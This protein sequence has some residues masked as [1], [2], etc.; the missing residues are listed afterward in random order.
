MTDT[1]I[2]VL[3][4]GYVGLTTAALLAASGFTTYIIDPNKQRLDSIRN[5]KS[6]FYEAGLDPLVAAG[7]E[8][9][10]LIPTDSYTEAIPESTIVFSAVGTP[11][12]S[13][14]SSN[15]EY[16]FAAAR[17]AARHMQPGS[18]YVQKS[19]VPVGTGAQVEK[20][21]ADSGKTFS[22]VSNPEFLRESTA[23]ADSL[24]PER[25]VVGGRD[26]SALNAV[27][28]IYKQQQH[29]RSNIAALAGITPPSDHSTEQYFMTSL[30]SAE[31]IK[32]SANAYLSL[33][34]SFANSIAKLADKTGAD[35]VEVMTA[36][37]ADRRIGQAFLN[38]GRGYGGGCF[39]KDVAGLISA[40][41]SF[42]VEP[43]IME[44]AQAVNESM[45]AYVIEKLQARLKK[46]IKQHAVAV[47]GLSFKAGTSD[48]R[49]SPGITIANLLA[50]S[51][52]QVR[53][54]DPQAM[55]EAE[56][57]LAEQIH[58]AATTVDALNGAD[59]VILATDWPEFLALT[60][61]DY[62]GYMKGAVF[63]D[64][65]NQFDKA[66]VEEASLQYVGVG[67]G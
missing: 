32:V 6:F 24:W 9:G 59:A 3:G 16:V 41:R 2:T 18:I 4:S 49:K 26:P 35:I 21:F 43:N 22:Y 17:E 14:G 42:G 61:Q 55:E 64:A 51:G 54:Y 8:H 29:V 34:I 52:A 19:T 57:E 45:P 46:P 65:V 50:S 27:I 11:D 30:E 5:G 62:R 15:L 67:R 36:V 20:L 48:T 66:V 33:K 39:P 60:P 38:A 47:L 56:P 58:R 25:I 37:G 31:L 1:T 10:R 23:I 63:V 40:S 28:N 53:A 7:L 44:A 13:D 12:N